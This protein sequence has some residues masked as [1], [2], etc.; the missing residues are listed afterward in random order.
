MAKAKL[1]GAAAGAAEAGQ[2]DRDLAEQRRDLVLAIVLHPA[3]G[4]AVPARR[5]AHGM[6]PGLHGNDLPLDARQH[7][8]ATL[9][10]QVTVRLPRFCCAGCGATELGF[11]HFKL[12]STRLR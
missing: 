8:I 12:G 11:G 9:F 5:T 6:N 2:A 1:S 4:A 3:S 10:G 7:E